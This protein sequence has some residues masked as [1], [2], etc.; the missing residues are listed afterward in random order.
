MSAAI[1][2][3]KF[4]RELLATIVVLVILIYAMLLIMVHQAERAAQS[5]DQDAFYQDDFAPGTWK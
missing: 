3:R 1:G 2:I 5:A 4:I